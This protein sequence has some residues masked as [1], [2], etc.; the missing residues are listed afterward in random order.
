MGCCNYNLINSDLF[1]VVSFSTTDIDD[2]STT[3]V[4]TR[5]S[6]DTSAYYVDA[7]GTVVLELARELTI[8]SDG[9]NLSVNLYLCY[10]ASTEDVS[11]WHTSVCSV[12]AGTLTLNAGQLYR[13]GVQFTVALS[14]RWYSRNV[15]INEYDSYDVSDFNDSVWNV[16]HIREHATLLAD[17]TNVG[18]SWEDLAL[19]VHQ[20]LVLPD[21]RF[22]DI[23]TIQP[24]CIT[25]GSAHSVQQGSDGDMTVTLADR[26]S[27]RI[28]T[29]NMVEPEPHIMLLGA[30]WSRGYEDA[31]ARDTYNNGINKVHYLMWYVSPAATA[32]HAD[33]QQFSSTLCTDTC[34]EWTGN[35]WDKPYNSYTFHVFDY[36]Y[37]DTMLD[38]GILLRGHGYV[39]DH[40]GEAVS[41]FK[42]A[43]ARVYFRNSPDILVQNDVTN[44]QYIT[45]SLDGVYPMAGR[46]NVVGTGL[47]MYHYVGTFSRY[48]MPTFVPMHYDFMLPT[49][50]DQL[51]LNDAGNALSLGI[52]TDDYI[53]PRYE[54]ALMYGNSTN[55]EGM[56]SEFSYRYGHFRDAHSSVVL[57]T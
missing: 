23:L 43:N 16:E 50:Q 17:N 37:N 3:G 25:V 57:T 19:V 39:R 44:T 21:S 54:D 41:G 30:G 5:Y 13:A 45:L 2:T 26:S 6:G 47:V 18:T 46:E 55:L 28:D 56:S 8:P 48:H 32:A 12:P 15:P 36:V 9:A 29:L 1:K 51:L 4:I 53:L 34:P 52:L 11:L 35:W 33:P 14:V 40:F 31:Y 42:N 38:L 27:I 22:S 24:S 49:L 7:V 20:N 10:D